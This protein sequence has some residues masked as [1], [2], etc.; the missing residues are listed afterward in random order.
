[1]IR[2]VSEQD[3]LA[4]QVEAGAAVH[5][6]LDHLKA[7][8]SR[9]PL[10]GPSSVVDDHTAAS[11]SYASRGWQRVLSLVVRH[12][13]GHRPSLASLKRACLLEQVQPPCCRPAGREN[14]IDLDF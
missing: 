8:R 11:R 9:S 1:V 4:E 6:A 12:V 2:S 3:A 13:S 14:A 10:K 5:L 7:G